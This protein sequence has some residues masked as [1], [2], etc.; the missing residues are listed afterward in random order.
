MAWVG[1]GG[2]WSGYAEGRAVYPTHLRVCTGMNGT[3][4]VRYVLRTGVLP[5]LIALDLELRWVYRAGAREWQTLFASLLSDHA[6]IR[7][8]ETLTLVARACN[9]IPAYFQ[10]GG[11]AAFWG[12]ME[13]ACPGVTALTV[14]LCD[15][16][17]TVTGEAADTGDGAPSSHGAAIRWT[18]AYLAAFR[19][20]SPEIRA[21][22][23]AINLWFY[24][25]RGI[26]KH[27]NGPV[28]SDIP[29]VALNTETTTTTTTT[30]RPVRSRR[31]GGMRAPGAADSGENDHPFSP[32]CPSWI[33]G[34]SSLGAHV[35]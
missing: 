32:Q 4:L 35:L 10:R 9:L 27:R 7:Y 30:N 2:G 5:A 11:A 16:P 12:L 1:G 17:E 25:P 19:A 29:D 14:D 34:N 26:F 13:R 20:G 28:S 15:N 31:G 23:H 8:V 3:Q 6:P 18:T 33:A 24:T 22:C 21:R